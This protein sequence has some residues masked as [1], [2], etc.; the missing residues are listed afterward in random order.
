MEALAAHISVGLHNSCLHRDLERTAEELIAEIELRKLT[1]QS[2]SEEHAFRKAV[3][4]R[5]AEGLCVC[6]EI[7]NYPFMHFTV[8]NDRMTEI[9]GYSVEAINELGWYQSMYPDLELQNKAIARMQRMRMGE[10]L[11][12]EEWEVTRA[13]GERRIFSISS[14]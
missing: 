2:L 12:G 13:D 14:R 4:E 8:W 3:I 11:H 6:H 7:E 1:E 5:A 10:D 9:T